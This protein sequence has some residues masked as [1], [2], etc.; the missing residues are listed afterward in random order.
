MFD[1]FSTQ[2]LRYSSMF[3][4]RSLLLFSFMGAMAACSPATFAQSQYGGGFFEMMANKESSEVK[5]LATRKRRVDRVALAPRA[6]VQGHPRDAEITAALTR[7]VDCEFVDTPL[8]DAIDFVAEH[9]GYPV[10]IDEQSLD[11]IGL[12]TDETVNLSVKNFQLEHLLKQMLSQLGITHMVIDGNVKITTPERAE[13]NLQTCIYPVGDLFPSSS[14]SHDSVMALLTSVVEPDSWDAA[15]GAGTIDSLSSSLVISQNYHVHQQVE[16]L[17]D[18]L[19]EL[20]DD[21]SSRKELPVFYGSGAA[22]DKHAIDDALRHEIRLP[23]SQ[24]TLNE[25]VGFLSEATKENV[26]VDQRG[27][28]EI[29]LNLEVDIARFQTGLSNI[30]ARQTSNRMNLPL[31]A[32]GMKN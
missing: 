22:S 12:G 8:V 7:T 18:V 3:H 26:L 20:R 5:L 25:F 4:Y 11:E 15:G 32:S 16:D 27:L 6:L 17:L 23:E 9:L 19:R 2:K 10:F 30:S 14:A 31:K 28:E 24:M 21:T 29:G 1:S 13:S